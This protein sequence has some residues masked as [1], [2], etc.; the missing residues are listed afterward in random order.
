MTNIVCWGISHETAGVEE[1]EHCVLSRDKAL[2]AM[3]LLK[4]Y[5]PEAECVALSTCNRTEF[6]LSSV[7]IP[8][9][10]Q[11]LRSIY[12][13]D[14]SARAWETLGYERKNHECVRHLLELATG[15]K[16]MVIGE[17]E[18]FGQMKDAYQL[19]F[20][21]GHTGKI[22]NR[23]FQMGFSAAKDARANT[24]IT[25]GSVS[26]GSVSVELAESIFGE[27]KNRHV[28]ILGAGDTSERVARTL[29]GKGIR[30][31]FVA[32]RTYERASSLANEL[33]GTAIRWDNWEKEL[34]GVDI[35]ISST[36]APHHVITL[37]HLSKCLPSRSY[38]PLF[39]IDLAVPR[40]IDP[41]VS[42][43]D[44]VYLYDLDDLQSIASTNLKE[45]ELEVVKCKSILLKHQLKF[46]EWLSRE[47]DRIRKTDS[48]AE[49]LCES[50]LKMLGI[51]WPQNH[52]TTSR[53]KQKVLYVP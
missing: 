8:D 30:S 27:L 32:N 23:L 38:K 13:C 52:A 40:D 22:L 28:L 31:V 4:S 21:S 50:C 46:M 51:R 25:K 18:I 29:A 7:S 10:A 49:N 26:V 42:D 12:E 44:S 2:R 45:R 16:S 11:W 39:L 6:Y 3:Q 19:S 20:D 9:R 35:I 41:L 36:S 24:A 5:E 37:Q 17:T 14:L 33:G 15:L 48:P 47:N 1:R 34:A 53:R 43:L